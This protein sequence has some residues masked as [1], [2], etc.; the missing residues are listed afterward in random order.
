MKGELDERAL[1][2]LLADA[3]SER[4][5]L[6]PTSEAEVARAE[7]AL[8]TSS[9]RLPARLRHDWQAEPALKPRVRRQW[10]G[11]ASAAA[12]GAMAASATFWLA[13]PRSAPTP[14]SGEARPA[15]SVPPP[16]SVPARLELSAPSCAKECCAGSQCAGARAGLA[17]CASGRTCLACG[18]DDERNRYRVRLGALALND[19]GKARLD[20]ELS[21][22]LELC[23]RVGDAPAVCTP[24]QSGTNGWSTLPLVVSPRDLLLG[25][26]VTVQPAADHRALASWRQPIAVTAETLCRGIVA[27]PRVTA[28]A[29][30]GSLSVLLDETHYVALAHGSDVRSVRSAADSFAFHGLTP[31]LYETRVEG[32]RG[33]ALVLGPFSH[34][35]AEQIRWQ[36]LAANRTA[37]VVLG[38]ELVGEP[39]P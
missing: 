39:Q 18:S 10:L 2:A 12:L 9:A 6:L 3:F 20:H 29:V 33:F 38:D 32:K 8:A 7:A 24:A 35:G 30:I 16:P 36:L 31:E 19:E 22:A 27:Q 15:A 17:Q 28:G 13:A 1:Q 11:Y 37:E 14:I 5:E 34:S 4:E 25:I 23:A 26:A 21:G